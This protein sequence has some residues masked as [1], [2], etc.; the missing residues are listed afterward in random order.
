MNMVLVRF[1]SPS[2]I[3]FP[4]FTFALYQQMGDGCSSDKGT[5]ALRELRSNSHV[6]DVERKELAA[7]T[8]AKVAHEH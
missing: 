8:A 7:T 4:L 2:Q 1:A 5:A 6:K 3:R